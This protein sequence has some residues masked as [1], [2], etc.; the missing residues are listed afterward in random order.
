M[1]LGMSFAFRNEQVNG[2]SLRC[3][4]NTITF[5]SLIEIFSIPLRLLLNLLPEH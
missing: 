2:V 5:V 4:L 1:L 3:W